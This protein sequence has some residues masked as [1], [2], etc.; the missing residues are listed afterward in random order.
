MGYKRIRRG[1]ESGILSRSAALHSRPARLAWPLSASAGGVETKLLRVLPFET[2]KFRTFANCD[3]S[4]ISAI[5]D[6]SQTCIV[7]TSFRVCIVLTSIIVYSIFS[8]SIDFLVIV[9]I[10]LQSRIQS[11]RTNMLILF[12]FSSSR[13]ELQNA[14]ST[15][16]SSSRSRSEVDFRL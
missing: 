15:E 4:R 2:A 11:T 6:L 7:S 10:A 1:L 8:I 3:V 12:L 16:S 9:Q 5:K 13:G 14:S